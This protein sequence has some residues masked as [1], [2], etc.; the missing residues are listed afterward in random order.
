[1]TISGM[2]LFFVIKALNGIAGGA[3]R[4]LCIISSELADMGHDVTIV[5][6]D[7][8][9][10]NS[11][12]P[13]S[14][15]VKRMI[16]GKKD[17]RHKST[18][19]EIISRMI[20]MR[21]VIQQEKPD[22]VIGFMH[23]IFVPLALSLIGT[24]IPVIASEH[25]VPQYYKQRRLEFLAMLF[26]SFFAK[27]ITVLSNPVKQ[28]Y[29][30]FIQPKMVIAPNPVCCF[31]PVQNR[32]KKNIILNV[33]RLDEQKDQKTLI[34]AFAILANRYPDWNL[35]IIGEGELRNALEK[36]IKQLGLEKRVVLPGKNPSIEQEYAHADIFVL[37]S[38]YESF[39]L[40]TAE[41]MSFG[42]PAIGFA[43]CPGTNE[44]IVDGL[45]GILASSE[46]R[47]HALA[48]A[49]EKL[50]VSP[51]MRNNMGKEGIKSIEIYKP[52]SIALIWENLIRQ[53]L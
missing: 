8:T 51:E 37:S 28:L 40:A 43:D 31:L 53:V 17:P 23:S 35:R 20:T 3:E 11:F 24:N 30:S 13:L 26:S 48:G 41:A 25:I 1:M 52:R 19:P 50:I 39:G 18:I 5:S 12:Y 16:L 22:A 10:E 4:V 14:P 29:P 34:D 49:M 9:S 6:F 21:R 47:A 7:H 2:K 27:K 45:N 44:I 15:N 46:N 33:G 32:N 36:Q 38:L 42:L